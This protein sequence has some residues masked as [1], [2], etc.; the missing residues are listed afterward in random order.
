MAFRVFFIR[1]FSAA[2][3]VVDLGVSGQIS[4]EITHDPRVENSLTDSVDPPRQPRD[5]FVDGNDKRLA[6]QYLSKL[7]APTRTFESETALTHAKDAP[8]V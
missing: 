3:G 8:L 5:K 7:H 2:L 6:I 1:M 4:G